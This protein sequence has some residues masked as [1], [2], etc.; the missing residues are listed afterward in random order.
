M[1]TITLAEH[2]VNNILVTNDPNLDHIDEEIFNALH[3][4]SY[5]QLEK[6]L[7]NR[8]TIED[9]SFVP[10]P[11]KPTIK[12]KICPDTVDRLM[13]FIPFCH[14]AQ[15]FFG[16][17]QFVGDVDMLTKKNR[18]QYDGY[19][20]YE[21]DEANPTIYDHHNTAMD[22][23]NLLHPGNIGMPTN[24][25]PCIT[26]FRF[27]QPRGNNTAHDDLPTEPIDTAATTKSIA[28]V[29]SPPIIHTTKVE[30]MSL[31]DV[32]EFL[33]LEMD[34]SEPTHHINNL[35]STDL[36]RGF[37]L[38]SEESSNVNFLLDGTGGLFFV[39]IAAFFGAAFD[40][41]F[42]CLVIILSSEF[43]RATLQE[44][45]FQE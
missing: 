13:P 9:I 29:P 4:K 33:S 17:S 3:G 32:E 20:R 31:R 39:C 2:V 5:C 41:S 1:S 18:S 40:F 28:K 26:T 19:I 12:K 16:P 6:M 22:I 21:Y 30:N 37:L 11:G 27:T 14:G 34:P 23:Y 25:G 42:D 35:T 7:S 10:D 44:W 24:V 36:N 8:A 45:A 15:M 38:S 43:M